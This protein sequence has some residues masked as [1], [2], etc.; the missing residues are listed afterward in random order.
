MKRERDNGNLSV[1][2]VYFGNVFA[3]PIMRSELIRSREQNIRATVI[4]PR[5]PH[6]KSSGVL[7]F[8]SEGNFDHVSFHFISLLARKVTANQRADLKLIRYVEFVARTLACILKTRADVYVGHDM[9]AMLP[10]F[11]GCWLTGRKMIYHAHEIW[12]E[13]GTEV[14]PLLKFWK[15]VERIVTRRADLVVVPEG[16]RAEI[17][18]REFGSRK[19]PVVVRNVP[20][21]K[22]TTR[23]L[24]L[25]ERIGISKE[26]VLVLYHGLLSPSRCLPELVDSL[27]WL[28]RNVH[29]VLLGSGEPA[30]VATL[31]E[32]GRKAGIGPR[33]NILPRVPYSDIQSYI[34]S[35]DVGI[36]LYRNRGRNNYFAA[37]NKFYEYTFSGVPVVVSD[38]PGLKSLV[39][40]GEFG[41]W[42]DPESP[43]DIAR[44]ILNVKETG[45]RSAL[46]GRAREMF[47][48]EKEFQHLVD[49]YR[50]VVGRRDQSGK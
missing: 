38:F 41:T 28:P 46:A 3:L 13:A 49:A 4:A 19:I 15:P 34:S 12:S 30:F 17:I 32:M 27:T 11:L 31:E 26:A 6:E 44:A 21:W 10:V 29:L 45:N 25:R 33:L 50:S 24:D 42:C 20:D 37:P 5:Y 48:W 40:E 8:P 47:S 36:V 35:A 9:P 7:A 16:N 23:R 14:S 22:P 18:Y 39:Q 43:E 1:C 2:H